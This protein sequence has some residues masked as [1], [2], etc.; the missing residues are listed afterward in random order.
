M[1][2]RVPV[3]ICIDVEPDEREV[4]RRGR[5][6]WLGF[7]ATRRLLDSYRPRAAAATG[8]P[9]AFSW[10]VRMDAQVAA[11]YDSP[12]W[13]AARYARE[14]EGLRAGG[15]ELGLHTHPW[16]WDGGRG[17]WVADF[18]DQSWVEHC[19]RLSFRAFE[20]GFGRPC[21]SF[22]FGDHWMNG[23]TLRLVEEL[24][25]AFD[26]T[27]EPGRRGVPDLP[28]GERHTGAF[29]DYRRVPREPYRPSRSDFTKPGD[30]E[31][32]GR[33]WLIPLSTGLMPPWPRAPLYRRAVWRLRYGPR[34]RLPLYLAHDPA[35]FRPAAEEILRGAGRPYLCLPLRS[36]DALRPETAR[37]VGDNLD[38]LLSHPSA[39]RLSFETPARAVARLARGR[40]G[41][42]R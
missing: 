31:A 33:L 3:L 10:F 5:E 42:V 15:D 18:G 34:R 9:A 38:F 1:T 2:R 32:H 21:A 19:V 7:E 36:D 27:L 26:L 25:A 37:R 35:C 14:F 24:G 22:R 8:A 13:A 40:R 29:P 17:S 20:E 4:S 39:A 28:P 12:A 6:D 11:A 23:E 30:R 16:R 41:E